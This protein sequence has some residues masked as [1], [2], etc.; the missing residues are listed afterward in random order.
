MIKN[1]FFLNRFIIE[2]N[3]E[4][5]N[6]VLNSI[7][8]QEKDILIIEF[9]KNNYN[10]FLEISV[11]P[12]S[13]YITLKE[14]YHRAKKNTID[15]FEV[16]TGAKFQSLSIADSDRILKISTDKGCLYFLIRGKFTNVCLIEVG[17]S[18]KYFKNPPDVINSEAL[19]D[20]LKAVNF[21]S[22]FNTNAL[23]ADLEVTLNTIKEKYPYIGKEIIS[24]AKYRCGNEE[25]KEI[26]SAIPEIIN[27]INKGELAVFIDETNYLLHL[28]V[29]TFHIFPYT[30]IVLFKDMPGA[31]N[32]Y[33]SK[34][35]YFEQLSYKKKRIGKHLEKELSRITSKLNNLKASIDKGSKE[36]E[37]NKLG[38]LLL[39]NLSLIRHGMKN[40]EVIDIYND[41]LPISIKLDETISPKK[42]VDYYFDKARS[43]KVNAEKSKQLYQIF[44]NKFLKLK[45]FEERFNNA[46]E[47]EDYNSIMKELKIKERN[48]NQKEH[49]PQFNFKQY[50]IESKY[51]VFVGKDSKNNDLLTTKFAKQNDYWFHARSVPGSHVVLRVE[52]NKETIPKP[53]LKKTASLAAYHSKA[54]TAGLVPV[55]YTQKKYV[56]KKKGMEPGKVALLREDVLIVK[57]EIPKDC[58]YIEK[59]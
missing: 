59:E 3:E 17:E 34:K 29:K 52:N 30:S 9:K 5:N 14:N 18:L 6:S 45:E 39:I 32:Y 21:I 22:H 12:G 8:S 13:P 56:V 53:I 41:N 43:Q 51:H 37:F 25:T 26:I 20:E 31:V 49:G 24:E 4:L 46:K 58:E 55:S 7:F 23:S 48:E 40:I 19:T 10:Y 2:I 27:E 50:L 44:S 33:I 54:K 11:N 35:Y 42:N 28:G 47:V 36:K 1:Y 16:I 38:N 57:P 15:F